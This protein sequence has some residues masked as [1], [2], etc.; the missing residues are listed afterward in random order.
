MKTAAHQI[1]DLLAQTGH[2]TRDAVK[3]L[4]VHKRTMD[5]VMTHLIEMGMVERTLSITPAGRFA[6]S[7]MVERKPRRRRE[8]PAVELPYSLLTMAFAPCVNADIEAIR[9]EAIQARDMEQ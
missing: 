4:P 9:A 3:A 2:A 8:P 5:N 1:L 7:Q 6:L